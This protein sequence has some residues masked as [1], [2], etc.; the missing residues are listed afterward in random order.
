MFKNITKFYFD[1]RFN[2]FD[3]CYFIAVGI[4]CTTSW[5][6]LCLILP[7]V[8]ASTIMETVTR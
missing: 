5:W 8:I 6:W 7:L 2:W 3:I 1:P 4:L